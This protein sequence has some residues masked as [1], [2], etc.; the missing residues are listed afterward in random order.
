MEKDC[1]LCEDLEE[2][3]DTESPEEQPEVV[4]TMTL[5]EDVWLGSHIGLKF[6]L[7]FSDALLHSWFDARVF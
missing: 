1:S 4:N 5:M 6:S 7:T 3:E 2:K